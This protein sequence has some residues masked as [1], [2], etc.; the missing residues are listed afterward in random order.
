MPVRVEGAAKAGV[1]SA[2]VNGVAL[3]AAKAA[4]RPQAEMAVVFVGPERIRALN[5]Y[6]GRD[7]ATDI[8]SFPA[9]TAAD[10]GDIFICPGAAKRKA[11]ERGLRYREYLELLVVHGV[12]HLAGLDHETAAQAKKMEKLEKKILD[13]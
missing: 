9:E 1:S 10:L 5:R 7:T 12:L 3:R 13:R 8:L 6:R 11:S 4:G 2:W